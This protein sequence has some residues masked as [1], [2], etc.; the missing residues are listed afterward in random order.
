MLK[1]FVAIKNVGTFRNSAAT[2]N[3]ELKRLTLIHAENGRGKTTLCAILR[4][5]QCG[6]S[7]LIVER[8]TL[9]SN[10]APHV[11]V[12]LDSGLVTFKNAAWASN[13]LPL[14]IF[15]AAFV[16]EN[17]YSGDLISHDHKKNLCRV[18][19]GAEGVLLAKKFD[20]LDGQVRTVG[21]ELTAAKDAVQKLVPNGI[22]IDQYI[23]I[24]PDAEIDRKIADKKAELSVIAAADP[25]KQK[26]L[27]VPIELP[28]P[29]STLTSTFQKTVDGVSADAEKLVREHIG[30]HKMVLAEKHG[31]PRGCA[32]SRVRIVRF[33]AKT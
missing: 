28:Q 14:E 12:L 4:S 27:L 3:S 10:N 26:P 33:V 23:A 32:T 22:T 24:T 19:I 29:P 25:I 1:K 17:V 2:G 31:C 6:D 9:D 21:N 20:E 5:F 16:A 8:K 30:S 15:D 7:N 18:V 11:E 13:Y